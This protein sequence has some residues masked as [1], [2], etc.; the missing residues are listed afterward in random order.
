MGA[1]AIARLARQSRA[2]FVF[3]LALLAGLRFLLRY[4]ATGA[5]ADARGRVRGRGV[6]DDGQRGQARIVSEVTATEATHQLLATTSSSASE[7]VVLSNIS[8]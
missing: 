4:T 5:E 7:P 1:F 8:M 2:V 3:A 6:S